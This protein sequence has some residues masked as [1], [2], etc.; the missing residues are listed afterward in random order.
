ME[1][2]TPEDFHPPLVD[3][4]GQAALDRDHAEPIGPSANRRVVYAQFPAGGPVGPQSPLRRRHSAQS[5]GPVA[6]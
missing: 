2:V 6:E 3:R 5:P 4:P 1:A